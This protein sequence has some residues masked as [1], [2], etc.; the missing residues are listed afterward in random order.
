MTQH[1]SAWIVILVF[2]LC[3]GGVG[4]EESLRLENGRIGLSFD[5]KTGT[6]TALENK[7]TAETYQIRGDEC[8]IDAV[9]FHAAFADLKLVSL[10]RQGDAVTARYEGK[11]MTVEAIYTLHGENH[12]AEKQLTLASDRKYGL[13][14]VVV[15]RPTFSAAGLR[16]VDYR[17]LGECTFFGRTAKGG[18]FTGMEVSFDDSSGKGQRSRPAVLAE[19]EG[20]GGREDGC[21]PVYFGVYRR[22]PH[23]VEQAG[24]PLRSESDAMV[25]MTSTILGP[26]RF[27][28]SPWVNGWCSEMHQ[29]DY[30]HQALG[31]RR[32]TKNSTRP[33]KQ[34]ALASDLKALEVIAQCGID[35][36]G[37]GHP[38][39]G[40]AA[41]NEHPGA[42]RSVRTVA[43]E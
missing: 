35:W 22:G 2:V 41:D 36:F 6:L 17:P 20:G 13:K 9:E 10:D 38:W 37:D 25:A 24:L 18:F 28:L 43:R 5:P 42:E 40:S 11:G 19:S 21:D 39:G 34:N 29:T 32:G 26:S 14:K 16:I 31:Q 3:T 4:A 1:F 30:T 27:G 23:D 12:F 33:V 7:L 15:S 8:D